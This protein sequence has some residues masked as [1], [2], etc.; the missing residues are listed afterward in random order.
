MLKRNEAEGAF[1]TII[2]LVKEEAEGMDAPEQSWTTQKPKWD[3]AL[4]LPIWAVLE[5]CDDVFP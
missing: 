5:E 2:R 3:E 1:L 4:P